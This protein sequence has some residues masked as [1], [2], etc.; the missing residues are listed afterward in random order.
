MERVV[1]IAK[2]KN[3]DCIELVVNEDSI[4][5]KLYNKIGFEKTKKEHCRLILN[6]FGK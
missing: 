2:E 4:A 3:I 6:R 1:S 5:R